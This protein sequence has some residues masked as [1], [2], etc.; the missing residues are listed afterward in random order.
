MGRCPSRPESQPE[1]D[2]STL[3]PQACLGGT[4]VH[5]LARTC[6]KN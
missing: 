2:S 4:E 5:T 6:S 1:K 3:W